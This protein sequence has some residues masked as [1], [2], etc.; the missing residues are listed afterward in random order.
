MAEEPARRAGAAETSE[1]AAAAQ[2]PERAPAV[3][4]SDRA[5]SPVA[6]AAGRAQRSV[7][8]AIL[9]AAILIVLGLLVQQLVTL[10][11]AIMMTIIVSLPLAWCATVLAR[12]G[13]PRTLGALLGLVVGVGALGGL[14]ALLIPTL[15]DQVNTLI[16]AAPGIVGQLET[17]IGH[18]IGERPGHVASQV[19]QF[20]AKYIRQPSKY[21]GPLASIGLNAATV[22]GGLVIGLITAYYMAARPEPLLSGV[23][24]M[25]PPRRREH[26]T[27]VMLRLRAA[28]LGWLR[29]LVISMVLVGLLLY[30]P[31]HLIVGLQFALVFAVLSAIAEVVPYLGAVVSGI[32]PVA[33]ALTVS[34]G[35]AIAVLVIYVAVHQIEAN[36]ISPLVM[37][38]SVHLHPTVIALGVVA[39]GEVFGFLGLIIAVPIISTITILVEE[40]W[41]RPHERGPAPPV[42]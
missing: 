29:G 2:T 30:L 24:R 35:T 32:P 10:L 33:F 14:M 22:L 28:L 20:V 9:L 17:T 6:G 39:V 18:S 12:R 8:G 26:V 31:L 13:V 1:R 41:V 42:P 23:R 27:E 38:R 15:V 7:F 21:L 36:I 40:M 16:N 11:L 5:M 37:A 3:Q 4:T 25:F 34:P 19:Q